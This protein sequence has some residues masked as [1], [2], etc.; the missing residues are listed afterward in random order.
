MRMNRP[1][2]ALAA[3]VAMLGVS[4]AAVGPARYQTASADT[5]TLSREGCRASAVHN[6]AA[7][8]DLFVHFETGWEADTEYY[9]G[10]EQGRDY[11]DSCGYDPYRGEIYDAET[12]EDETPPAKPVI[13][14][15]D[16]A[17]IGKVCPPT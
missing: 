3:L 16:D 4:V 8:A 2:Y 17:P 5:A 6:V 10:S 9:S 12:T 11:D 13:P 7:A 14:E 1:Y 15:D